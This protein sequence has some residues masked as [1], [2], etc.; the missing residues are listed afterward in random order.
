MSSI[1]EAL[2]ARER[3]LLAPQAARSAD[4]RGRLRAET[5]DDVR[6][7]FQHDR[8]RIIHSKAFRRLKHK[9]Q[10]FLA[11]AG[12]HY[13]TR[14][15]HTLEVSQIAR[16]IAKVLRLHEEL[17]EAI[18]LGHD[19]GHTPFGHAGERVLDSLMP[20]GFRHYEQSLRIVDVLENDGRGLNLSFEV[21]DGI[22]RHSKGK[23]GS[24]VGMDPAKRAAT[25][26]GQIMRVADLIAYV[27]HDID[28]A[29]RAGVL[30]EQALPRDAVATLGASSSAR[31][32]RMVKDVVT[33][34]TDGGLSEIR[35]SGEV[36]EATLAIRAFLFEAVYEND[37]AT[38]EFKKSA[39]ILGGLWEKVREHPGE[40]LDLHII[41]REGVDVAV[42]D[43]LAGMTD[44][45]AIALYER[46]FIPK[47]W[48]GPM[49]WNQL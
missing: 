29:V 35:M 26:E 28:D 23:D 31:I 36:L 21:R 22:G 46:L 16:T 47:P 19:L 43:F 11:P 33:E 37:R 7:A 2:E 6:P 10:V 38:A 8:D 40:L 34:T 15:T 24:P 14:L 48:I 18:A 13:R 27:N 17:T 1:R 39:G 25:L 9:T 3:E 12:D 45:F 41:E 5:E 20:G 49:T 32:A 44:R 4:S 30:E 42:R